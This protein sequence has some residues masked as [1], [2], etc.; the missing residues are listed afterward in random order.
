MRL[1]RVLAAAAVAA[2]AFAVA[3]PAQ[4]GPYCDT[5]PEACNYECVMYPCYPDDW[6][7]YLL[8][9]LPVDAGS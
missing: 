5:F 8:D 4:A 7:E 9:R 1:A 6:A 2:G 3:T